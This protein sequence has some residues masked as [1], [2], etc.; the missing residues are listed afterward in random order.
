M[1]PPAPVRFSTTTG[2]A[3][4]AESLSPTMRASTS[5]MPPPGNGTTNLIARVGYPV[6][7]KAGPPTSRTARAA[8]QRTAVLIMTFPPGAC[9]RPSIRARAPHASEG[10]SV[11][12]SRSLELQ[13]LPRHQVLPHRDLALDLRL[14]R[15]RRRVSDRHETLRDQLL[16]QHRIGEDFRHVGAHLL[17]DRRWRAGGRQQA[18]PAVGLEIGQPSFLRGRR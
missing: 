11:A 8:R 4:F 15:G 12:T 9:E 6:C 5:L 18:V 10:G 7:A 2:C 1:L 13:L 3:H 17:D 14:E 16:L